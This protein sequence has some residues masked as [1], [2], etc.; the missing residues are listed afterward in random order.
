M[1]YFL[2]H[3]TGNGSF[4]I[5]RLHNASPE[6]LLV[7]QYS[8]FFMTFV[9]EMPRSLLQHFQPLN[10]ASCLDGYVSVYLEL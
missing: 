2:R 9:H 10:N 8:N 7:K 3:L 4:V 5:I 1:Q 6:H